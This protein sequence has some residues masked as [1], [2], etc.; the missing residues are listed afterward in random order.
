M[1]EPSEPTPE[2]SLPTAIRGLDPGELFARGMQTVKMSSAGG[3]RGWT[4]P[5]VEEVASFFPNYEVLAILGHGGMGAVYKARQIALDRLVALKLLPL[6][7]SV[8]RDFADRF[9]REARAMAKLNHPHIIAVHDFGQTSEGQL[10]F[11]MEFVEGSN[12]HDI[13]RQV[14]LNP[15][16]ALFV[17]EQVC[18]AL[19]YAHG[20]GIVHRDIKPANVMIDTESHVKVADFGLARLTEPTADISGSTLTG[21]VMG[22]PGYM[23]PEQMRGMNVD[24]RADI[25]SLGVMLY[26]MLCRETPQGAF[27][28]PSQRIGCDARIDQIV[29]KA[30][31]QAPEHRYQSTTEM[32]AAVE[33]ARMPLPAPP[34]PAPPLRPHVPRGVAPAP[35]KSKALPYGAIMAVLAALAAGAL[36]WAKPSWRGSRAPAL[37][38]AKSD[39][40]NPVPAQP[41]PAPPPVPAPIP[42]MSVEDAV[43][44]LMGQKGWEA[45][46][47]TAI[48][49]GT[50]SINI[51][52]RD[53][54]DLAPLV[55]LPVSELSAHGNPI[56]DLGPLRGLPL[57]TLSLDGLPVSDL[58]PLKDLPLR[59]LSLSNNRVTD[60][61]SLRDL[62][63]VTLVLDRN[64]QEIDL[65]PL[66]EMTT[67]EDLVLPEHPQNLERLRKLPNLKFISNK[68]DG[69]A[70]KGSTNPAAEFWKTYDAEQAAAAAAAMAALN[71]A[72]KPLSPT[73][74]WLAEQEP[75]W[76]A[77]FAKEVS[78]PFENG[79]ADAR[80]QYV[81][82]L[83]SKIGAAAN[84]GKRDDAA[85]FR[86]DSDRLAAG[87]DLPPVD[88]TG[89]P[90][91][92]KF[93]RTS[94]RQSLAAVEASRLTK[95]QAVL[96]RY[97][98]ILDQNQTLLTQRQRSGEALEIKAKRGQL[99]A[100]WLLPPL[101]AE[102]KN[103][104]V[105]GLVAWWRADGNARDSIGSHH[106]PPVGGAGFAEGRE[107][108]AF[109][110]TGSASSISVAGSPAVGFG[111]KDFSI[112]LWAKFSRRSQSQAL[113]SRGQ[114]ANETNQWVFWLNDGQLQWKMTGPAVS[115]L[116]SA[117]FAP[118]L[119][120]WYRLAM[121]R[122]GDIFRFF[123]DGV[124]VSSQAWPG[125]IPEA[126]GPL[127]LGSAG[128][129]APFHGLLDDIRIYNRALS[130]LEIKAVLKTGE[131][132]GLSWNLWQPISA[133]AKFLPEP[134]HAASAPDGWVRV[135]QSMTADSGP[136]RRKN[137]AIRARFKFVPN[138]QNELSLRFDGYWECYFATVEAG[139]V[140]RIYAHIKTDGRSGKKLLG[141]YLLTTRF[142]PGD[143]YKL[144]LRAEG[145][146]IT[147][148]VDDQRLGSVRDSTH[149]RAGLCGIYLSSGE[150][151]DAGWRDLGSEAA[152][153]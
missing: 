105:N 3:T 39:P 33:T 10:F 46:G 2:P 151:R 56:T 78:A 28:P 129:T 88:D 23:A 107:G 136:R 87:G 57:R 115:Q 72:P 64:T 42:R 4:P 126:S 9:R 99:A 95:A 22:T 135:G 16:Q 111:D 92:V 66:A 73:G 6:E 30:M 12:L 7:V 18:A 104:P 60:L 113:V 134:N 8:N 112:V 69:V 65:A 142:S 82:G 130:A 85:A 24:H 127:T 58:A 41:T 17:V 119:G 31:Q 93:L 26:E 51:G 121:T 131:P 110:F 152:P 91:A 71:A 62:K 100:A 137:A 120:Q 1:N 103:G 50:I 21:L 53:I 74:K 81:T 145:E 38:S 77:A 144:E 70:A 122:T 80:K 124:E 94:Y 61:S 15:E 20:K 123:I 44:R 55:G 49:D 68:W 48:P 140:A 138:V 118:V 29:L 14:G 76:Q 36:F 59:K 52:D 106:G 143:E 63:L 43:K 37:P 109:F 141:T 40:I 114:G 153:Q 35:A 128:G 5:T 116:G 96:A 117:P 125:K 147:V 32:N 47:I 19:A 132:P 89:T 67:L 133:K 148:F 54:A 108:Q 98:A 102:A 84:S 75:Q 150:F 79:V 149:T 146:E 13:I 86:A 11:A 34:A 27:T 25:Y 83:N 45:I 139:T 90:M 97:D 101:S